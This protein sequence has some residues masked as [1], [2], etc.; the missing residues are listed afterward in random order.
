M[1]YSY[2]VQTATLNTMQNH[3]IILLLRPIPIEDMCYRALQ[4]H[5]SVPRSGHF[6]LTS[7]QHDSDLVIDQTVQSGCHGCRAGSSPAGKGNS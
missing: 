2:I 4:N 5:L 7:G 6:E 1:N 3:G